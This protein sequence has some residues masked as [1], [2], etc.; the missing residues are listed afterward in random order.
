LEVEVGRLTT[1]A[2]ALT[3]TR[4]WWNNTQQVRTFMVF[5]LESMCCVSSRSNL[6]RSSVLTVLCFMMHLSAQCCALALST[7]SRMLTQFMLLLLLLFAATDARTL[8]GAVAKPHARPLPLVP[9]VNAR[10]AD[11]ALSSTGSIPPT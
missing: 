6:Q 1:N 9:A 8:A 3:E 10:H 11:S 7:T 4:G 2:Q 5:D